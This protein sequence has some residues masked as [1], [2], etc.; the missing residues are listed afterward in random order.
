MK[1][2]YIN[3]L[4]I[5]EVVLICVMGLSLFQKNIQKSVVRATQTATLGVSTYH[6]T[7]QLPPTKINLTQ[8]DKTNDN[9]TSGK[10]ILG[11]LIQ[12][13]NNSVESVNDYFSGSK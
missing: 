2:R 10:G 13:V 6:P 4:F 9:V 7:D 11:L 1:K 5:V 3:L 8:T 12:L